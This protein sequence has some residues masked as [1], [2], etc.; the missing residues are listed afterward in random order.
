MPLD[1]FRSLGRTGLRI[2]PLGLGAMLFDDPSWGAD[3]ETSFRMLD[4]YRDR[5]G[6]FVD[7]SNGYARGRSEDTIGEYLRRHP[8]LRDRMVIATKFAS[9]LH[10]G[11]PNSG[12]GGRKAIYSQ[13]D[14]SLERL[15]TDYV[16]LYWFHHFDPHTPISETVAAVHDL[17]A[18]GKVRYFGI[19]DSPAWAVAR[20]GTIAEFRGWAPVSAIQIEYSLL[21]R[22][23]EG[24]LFGAARELGAGGVSYSPLAGGVLSGKYTRENLRPAGSG[25]AA[26]PM[27]QAKL[28]ESTFALLDRLREIADGHA[29]TVSAVAIAWQIRRPAITSA[30]VGARTVE[31]LEAN[32]AAADL[33]LSAEECTSL[34]E[35]TEPTLQFPYA[36]LRDIAVHVQQGG[37]TINGVTSRRWSVD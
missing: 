1:H 2:S 9:N 30:L 25:R 23:P 36:F 6:N 5:G 3:R 31:Q 15:G 17:V 14:G 32:L 20:A 16:D 19:S 11:D 10:P 4:H 13:L 28:T 7:T 26:W 37:A 29:T 27:S 34:D 18:A 33:T 12:G 35:L 22:T 21:E 24:E 8:G